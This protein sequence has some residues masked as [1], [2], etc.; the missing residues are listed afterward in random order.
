MSQPPEPPPVQW[1]PYRRRP[2]DRI[3]ITETSCCGAYEWA[4]QGGLFLILRP[5]ARP[6]RYEEAG[7]GLYRQA[8]M[9]W[10][11]LL[12]YHER[13]HQYEQAAAS[14]SRPRESR[15]GEQAA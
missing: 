5:T 7:R 11:A 15:D 14:K 13:R 6:G 2:R 10:E 12:T 8:R 1:E 3:R 9:V 4:A